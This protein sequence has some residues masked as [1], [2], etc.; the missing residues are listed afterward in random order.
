MAQ[1]IIRTRAVADAKV[2]RGIRS[3]VEEDE[4]FTPVD[5]IVEIWED[6]VIPT[7][8]VAAL[9]QIIQIPGMTKQEVRETLKDTEERKAFKESAIA[10][11]SFDPPVSGPTFAQTVVWRENGSSDS[12]KRCFTN[13]KRR[14]SISNLK[15]PDI[16]KLKSTSVIKADKI[17]ILESCR[18]LMTE[19][20]DNQ[21]ILAVLPI[22]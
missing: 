18:N 21:T 12:W 6:G 14:R 3:S 7:S 22:S 11:W 15:V 19:R 1:L 16:N 4:A 2:A 10:D 9:Y 20:Q 5:A 8:T 13:T 17:L